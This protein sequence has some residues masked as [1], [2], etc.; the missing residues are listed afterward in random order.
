MLTS[1]VL[2]RHVELCSGSSNL[3]TPVGTSTNNRNWK[4]KWKS[5]DIAF[6]QH[7]ANPLLKTLMPQLELSA[8]S[9]ILVPLCG[10]SHDM[11]LLT[12]LGY[13]VIGVELSL[14]AIKAYFQHQGQSA[15]RKKHKRL[16]RWSHADTAIWCG[17]IFD[18]QA[19]D[20][21]PVAAVYDNAALTA[22]AADE[23][24]AYIDHI[25]ELS[26]RAPI[27]LLTAETPSQDSCKEVDK[28]VSSLYAA[29]YSIKL[30]HGEQKMMQDP[31]LPEQ[32]LVPMYEKAYYLKN[33]L[34]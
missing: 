1:E 30:L 33:T 9:P 6:H 20:I 12:A 19:E 3:E 11:T 26:N 18:L 5:D 24:A 22:F 10:K 2:Y 13:K 14:I 15:N 4:E 23:R 27:L 16:V 17:N 34:N 32:G 8:G 31:C 7:R 25:S 28:E 21:G 29:N